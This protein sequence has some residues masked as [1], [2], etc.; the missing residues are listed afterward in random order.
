MVLYMYVQKIIMLGVIFRVGCW[1]LICICHHKI[2]WKFGLNFA[3]DGIYSYQGLD[4][5]RRRVCDPEEGAERVVSLFCL[6]YL[7]VPCWSRCLYSM[8]ISSLRI[9]LTAVLLLSK[10]TVGILHWKRSATRSASARSVSDC[11]GVVSIRLNWC[12]RQDWCVMK[13]QIFGIFFHSWWSGK[14]RYVRPQL[15]PF[16][17]RSL[18]RTLTEHWTDARRLWYENGCCRFCAISSF[19]NVLIVVPFEIRCCL[20]TAE[21]RADS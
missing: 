2:W 13:T 6:G 5:W 12:N 19:S 11:W 7:K 21:W 10:V 14:V 20:D 1:V 17:C 15:S 8:Y 4:R 18:F 3:D 16:H 9:F